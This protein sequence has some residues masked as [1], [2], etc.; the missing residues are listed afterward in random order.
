MSQ[1]L[2]PSKA[3]IKQAIRQTAIGNSNSNEIIIGKQSAMPFVNMDGEIPNKTKIAAEIPYK[4]T[5]KYP[6]LLLNAWSDVKEDPCKWAQKA[7]VLGADL[8]ALR[9]DGI[10]HAN[11]AT[12]NSIIET[13]RNIIET[14][15]LPLCILNQNNRDLDKYYLPLIAAGLKGYNCLIGPVEEET[16]K[17]IIPA[18]KEND[19]CVIARTPIDV[20]LAKQLNI[21][22]TE[23]GINPDKIVIDPNMG[24]LGYGLDYAYSVV[25]RIRSAA[26]DGDIMLNMPI[27]VFAGEEA[28]RTKETKANISDEKWGDHSTRAITWETLTT[29]SMIMVGADLVVMKHPESIK[30]ISNFIKGIN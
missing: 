21:L 10:E 8:I 17:D 2:S 9:L 13:A 26:F 11:E 15:N 18:L 29:S 12:A 7:H 4:I 22:I 25:E 30:Q 19:H 3:N 6:E 1:I 5:A 16:Y 14:T 23:L 28:W 20:N 24:G 27:T